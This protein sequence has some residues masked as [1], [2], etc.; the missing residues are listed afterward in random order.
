METKKLKNIERLRELAKARK[1]IAFTEEHKQKLRGKI[2]W[3]KN[4]NMWTKKQREDMS[5]EK[6]TAVVNLK[7]KTYE[8]IYGSTEK[9]REIIEKKKKN[10]NM[11]NSAT[12][13]LKGRTYEDIYGPEKAKE[14]KEKRRLMTQQKYNNGTATFGFPRDGTMKI[15]RSKQIFPKNDTKIE[16]KIQN[17]LK[18]LKLDFWTH[19]Y[20]SEI[21]HAYQSDILIEPQKNFMAEKK[22]II[23]VDGDWWHGNE[24]VYP[25]LNEN[26]RCQREEDYIRTKELKEKGFNVIRIWESDINR[27]TLKEFKHI[28]SQYEN[29]KQQ[30]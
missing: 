17:F 25:N 21:E 12:I 3:N 29:I 23:E 10:Y 13:N 18:E 20:M 5:G 30:I 16:V 7:G 4:I 8:Q 27:M 9:A 2:T 1:G 19:H 28:L 22:T 26:Q 14:Q 24:K 6:N 15:R 11:I